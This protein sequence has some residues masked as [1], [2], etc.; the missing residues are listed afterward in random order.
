MAFTSFEGIVAVIT[1]GASGIGLASAR[2]LRAKGAHIVLVD[3][4][5]SNEPTKF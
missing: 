5:S 2:A 4:N 1:G 3:V